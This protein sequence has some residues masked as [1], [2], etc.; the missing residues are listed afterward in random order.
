M[1][2]SSSTKTLSRPPPVPPP[3]PPPPPPLCSCPTP[4][5]PPPHD[6]VVLIDFGHARH[7]DSPAYDLVSARRNFQKNNH[8]DPSYNT[9]NGEG[10]HIDNYS[11]SVLLQ[12][13]MPSDDFEMK[14]HLRNWI[15]SAQHEDDSVR[16]RNKLNVVTNILERAISNLR[17]VEAKCKVLEQV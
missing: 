13:Y 16:K 12:R 17:S 11:L 5:R 7:K 4:F 3:P 1:V 8:C 9:E 10:P 15:S 2:V 6:K 14:D